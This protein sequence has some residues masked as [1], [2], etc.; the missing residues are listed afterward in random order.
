MN[1]LGLRLKNNMYERIERSGKIR[2]QLKELLIKKEV[3]PSI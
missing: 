1:M 3:R 2:I